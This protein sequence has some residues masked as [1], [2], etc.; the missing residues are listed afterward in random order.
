MKADALPPSPPGPPTARRIRFT[1][2]GACLCCREAGRARARGCRPAARSLVDSARRGRSVALHCR[3]QTCQAPLDRR[4]CLIPHARAAEHAFPSECHRVRRPRR[5]RVPALS[6]RLGERSVFCAAAAP[7]AGRRP[8]LL[9]LA[10]ALV[11]ANI[12]CKH[13]R[14][15]CR[16]SAGD[17]HDQRPRRLLRRWLYAKRPSRAGRGRQ[18]P[19]SK[20][21]ASG[22][23]PWGPLPCIP[24]WWA[25]ARKP[26]LR[27]WQPEYEDRRGSDDGQKQTVASP[28]QGSG[29]A[30]RWPS[31]LLV[32]ASVRLAESWALRPARAEVRSTDRPWPACPWGKGVAYLSLLHCSRSTTS[33]GARRPTSRPPLPPHRG[34]CF[35]DAAQFKP[36]PVA[37][38]P[39]IPRPADEG[40]YTRGLRDPGD[41]HSESHDPGMRRDTR[42]ILSEH[43]QWPC[44]WGRLLRRSSRS[45]SLYGWSD[46]VGWPG[47]GLPWALEIGKPGNLA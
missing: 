28:R 20:P 9:W 44:G 34:Q 14:P 15:S 29:A 43:A 2:V 10:S 18:R 47:S 37:S 31:T 41:W 7:V 17:P 30:R 8:Q 39:S 3:C 16:T 26:V 24:R 38:S 12:P 4:S 1:A 40:K 46:R 42:L 32:I 27:P 11:R 35:R 22:S 19:A 45:M 36:L 13:R 21:A 33:A 25:S 5:C 6:Y 23:A